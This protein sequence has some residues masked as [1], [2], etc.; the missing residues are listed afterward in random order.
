MVLAGTTTVA[1]VGNIAA[2]GGLSVQEPAAG[3]RIRATAPGLADALS[4]L[5]DVAPNWSSI[6]PD[7]GDIS[8]LGTDPA[9]S[10]VAY[11]ATYGCVWKTTDGAT[12]WK[13]A[14]RGLVPMQIDAL[15]VHPSASA[16]IFAA[17]SSGLY[18]STDAGDTWSLV[19][20]LGAAAPY[21]TL[22]VAV[23]AS[24][25]IYAGTFADGLWRLDDGGSTWAPLADGLPGRRIT[26]VAVEP[27]STEVIYAAAVDAD[28]VGTV[29]RSVDRGDTWTATALGPAAVPGVKPTALLVDPSAATSVFVGT[30][31]G[32]YE[33]PDRGQ[34]FTQ[35]LWGADVRDLAAV[36][37]A[38][39][40]R[41]AAGTS[42]VW[43]KT[44]GA[45]WT[46]TSTGLPSAPEVV[47]VAVRTDGTPLAGTRYG[48]YRMSG[49]TWSQA[50]NGLRALDTSAVGSGRISGATVIY[51]ATSGAGVYRSLNGGSTWTRGSHPAEGQLFY[52]IAVEPANASRAWLAG[53]SGL[54]RTTDSGV[55]WTEVLVS[56]GTIYSTVLDPSNDAIVYAGGNSDVFRSTSG[57]TASFRDLNACSG[58]MRAMA[59]AATAPLALWVGQ[60]AGLCKVNLAGVNEMFVP[61]AFQ[62][63]TSGLV[64]AIA[65]DPDPALAG[66]TVWASTS[67]GFHTTVDGGAT[68]TK[69]G[70]RFDALLAQQGRLFGARPLGALEVSRDGGVTFAPAGVGLYHGRVRALSA[71]PGFPNEIYAGTAW[72]SVFKTTS[73]GE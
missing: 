2:F 57:T 9:A 19:P 27:A 65:V 54:Y 21:R 70:D 39:H 71:V 38:S 58:P 44:G 17:G 63:G 22:A 33:S 28:E 1:T 64:D 30:Q 7:G 48:V 49:T 46:A 20:S 73:G 42:G 11:A 31:T 24:G 60:D 36:Q 56:Q 68:W 29:Y 25:A 41:Y 3:Y 67:N 35:T 16:R 55:T 37:G 32:V 4:G 66:S 53:A 45:E 23:A 50:T 40:V 8:A 47:A 69:T 18:L 15:V 6:G 61:Y 72:G 52:A 51:A 59:L 10:T 5:F 14:C 43:R 26:A 12:S 62:A 34:T 13:R